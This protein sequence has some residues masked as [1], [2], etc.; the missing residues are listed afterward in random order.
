M[1]SRL[2]VDQKTTPTKL[3]PWS[4]PEPTRAVEDAPMSVGIQELSREGVSYLWRRYRKTG[5]FSIRNR[6]VL[7]LSPLVRQ[8]VFKRCRHLPTHCD[9]DDYLSCGLEALIR[10]IDRY[11][12]DRGP[13][14]EQFVWARIHGA[15]LDEAR[16]QDWA[17]R[18][19]RSFGREREKVI[20]EYTS[21]HGRPPERRELA[22][23]LAL[24]LEELCR[25]DARLATAELHSLN[26]PVIEGGEDA[27]EL[28]D[29]IT[30]PDRS[31]RPE[32]VVLAA[33][34]DA[35]VQAALAGLSARDR[36]VA[37]MLYVE[38][39]TMREVGHRLGVTES[40][41]SQLNSR[42]KRA[43]GRALVAAPEPIAA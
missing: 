16:R 37:E 43:V 23:A 13:T 40:R 41:V 2:G 14:L 22:D 1:E 15:V 5:D 32:D 35:R 33:D 38:D 18:S 27:L 25:L 12:P 31:S 28:V 30:S 21:L 11:D 36:E 29:T 3:I 17:P 19:L 4:H 10:A 39:M 34:G 8:I 20:R 42:I 6:L 26:A 9:I 24:S 7:E